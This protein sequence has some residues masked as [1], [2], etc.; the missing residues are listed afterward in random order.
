MNFFGRGGFTFSWDQIII[1]KS[2]GFGTGRT[3]EDVK[4]GLESMVELLGLGDIFICGQIS[5][6][7]EMLELTFQLLDL[8]IGLKSGLEIKEFLMTGNILLNSLFIIGTLILLTEF[9][10][11]IILMIKKCC[12]TDVLFCDE[13]FIGGKFRCFRERGE[14]AFNGFEVSLESLISETVGE[15]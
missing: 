8:G 12:L 2:N 13:F 14:R 5:L 11:L 6:L 7:K 10:S 3:A 9:D 1:Y 15:R 4:R